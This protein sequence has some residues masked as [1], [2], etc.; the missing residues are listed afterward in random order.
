MRLLLNG[1]F[2]FS[3]LLLWAINA[4]SQN[5]IKIQSVGFNGTLH[6]NIS[7]AKRQGSGFRPLIHNAYPEKNLFRNDGV[8]FNF[9][10]IFNG[11]KDQHKISMFTPRMDTCHAKKLKESKYQLSWPSQGSHWGLAAKMIY[12]FSAPNQ[13][14]IDFQCSP[15]TVT[16]YSKGYIAMMWASYMNNAIDRRIHFWGKDGDE[17]GWVAFGEKND[18]SME[19]GTVSHVNATDLP[20]E[21]GAQTLNLVTHPHKKFITPFYYGILDADQNIETVGDEILYLV[22][23]D[24]L[25]NIRFAMWN[26]IKNENDQPDTHS[27]AWDWQFIVREPKVGQTYKYKTRVVVKPY[28]GE[29]QI[30]REYERWIKES[31]AALPGPPKQR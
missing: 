7:N 11:A 18:G 29:N 16:L 14:D 20:F 26:F 1:S 4:H 28:K 10:H 2:I 13:V 12:D 24:Q 30:W 9:E 3:C 15:E 8:G 23:F 5:A 17:T 31:K 25:T 19:V 27:P 6:D 21:I 22:M